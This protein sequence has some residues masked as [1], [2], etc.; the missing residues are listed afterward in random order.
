MS[1][2]IKSVCHATTCFPGVTVAD[3]QNRVTEYIDKQIPW[4]SLGRAEAGMDCLGVILHLY[5]SFGV[6]AGDPLSL[7]PA[8]VRDFVLADHWV[9][10]TTIRTGDVVSYLS[11]GV[12]QHLGIILPG[13]VFHATQA[14]G[15]AVTPRRLL[16]V[17][18]YYSHKDLQC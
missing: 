4:V 1:E 3:V 13:A 17:V 11:M 10:T 16:K 8:H 9:P 18:G 6:E 2:R 15:V 5:R 12:E 7:D 14:Q